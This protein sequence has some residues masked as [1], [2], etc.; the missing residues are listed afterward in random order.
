[1]TFNGRNKPF[2]LH[3]FSCVHK[4]IK[5][6]EYLQSD[7]L[8]FVAFQIFYIFFHITCILPIFVA[9]HFPQMHNL[10]IAHS[11]KKYVK[12]AKQNTRHN[13]EQAGQMFAFHFCNHFTFHDKKTSFHKRSQSSYSVSSVGKE[14][15]IS[16]M[17]SIYFRRVFSFFL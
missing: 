7:H 6:H 8:R 13:G 10:Q 12:Y 1:M 3:F 17:S 2:R 11:M 9:I 14:Y 15:L 5:L 16:R 4:N